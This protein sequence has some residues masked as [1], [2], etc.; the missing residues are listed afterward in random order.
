MAQSLVAKLMHQPLTRVRNEGERGA[1]RYYAEAL[2]DLFGLDD[3]ED[4]S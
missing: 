3:G 2:R 4:E 1:S